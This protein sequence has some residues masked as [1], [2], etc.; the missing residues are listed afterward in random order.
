MKTRILFTSVLLFGL[1]NLVI[2]APEADAFEQALASKKEARI[3]NYGRVQGGNLSM[4]EKSNYNLGKSSTEI[5][6]ASRE[7]A[8][9]RL[10]DPTS[11]SA[12]S[13]G[14]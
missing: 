1:S 2:A 6:A 3:E 5:V 10:N 11:A 8:V 14:K 4:V 12:S 9:V 13:G 7:T